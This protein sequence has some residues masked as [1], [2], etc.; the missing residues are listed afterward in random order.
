ML[1][2]D[3]F[4]YRLAMIQQLLLFV[5]HIFLSPDEGTSWHRLNYTFKMNHGIAD[6]PLLFLS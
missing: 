4:L 1:S 6:L 3:L 5:D 2:C